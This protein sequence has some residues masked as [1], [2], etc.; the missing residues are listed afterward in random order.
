MERAS[1]HGTWTV[2]ILKK[3]TMTSVHPKLEEGATP[4]RNQK[5]T[6]IQHWGWE[7][8]VQGD[9]HAEKARNFIVCGWGG[10]CPGGGC[11]GG[12]SKVTRTQE[13][14]LATQLTVLYFMV[15]GWVSRLSL[16]NHSDP[17]SLLVPQVFLCQDGGQQEGLWEVVGPMASPLDLSQILPVGGS[18]LLVPYSSPGPP[19]V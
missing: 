13:N 17:G 2:L 7:M 9:I 5:G 1:T 11:P 18:S 3:K 4:S 12:D 19:A 10:G 15:M 8:S 14:Y 16:A 6:L